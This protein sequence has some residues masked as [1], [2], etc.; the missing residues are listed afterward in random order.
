MA[1]MSEDAAY[2]EGAEDGFWRGY[3]EGAEACRRYIMGETTD[4]PSAPPEFQPLGDR[5][6]WRNFAEENQHG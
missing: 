3:M 1:I 6:F 2:M 4:N 5:Y